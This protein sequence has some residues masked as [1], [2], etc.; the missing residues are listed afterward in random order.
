MPI[1]VVES[2]APKTLVQLVVEQT[3]MQIT[4]KAGTFKL[5]DVV[6]TLE[7]DQE[8][9]IPVRTVDTD[10]IGYLVRVKADGKIAV[11]VDEVQR[12]GLDDLYNFTSKSPWKLISNLFLVRVPADATTLDG[13]TIRV[14]HVLELIPPSGPKGGA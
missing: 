7:E 6:E 13:E 11:F 4:V 14:D 12:D 10:V 3:G 2:R 8:V 5:S 1:Q 9:T